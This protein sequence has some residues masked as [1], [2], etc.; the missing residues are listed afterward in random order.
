MVNF[1]MESCKNEC[2]CVYKAKESNDQDDKKTK[3]SPFTANTDKYV[4]AVFVTLQ[5]PSTFLFVERFCFCVLSIC[6][7]C[8][9]K[10]MK[11]FS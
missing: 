2:V 11:M 10:S 4:P 3:I 1:C 5:F 8:V 6:S 9:V 7:M